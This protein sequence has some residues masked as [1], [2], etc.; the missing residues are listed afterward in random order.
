MWELDHCSAEERTGNTKDGDDER[1]SIGNVGGPGAK[2]SASN[3]LEVG[4]VRVVQRIAETC[5]S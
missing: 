5:K 2:F 3:S 4:Q 1:V